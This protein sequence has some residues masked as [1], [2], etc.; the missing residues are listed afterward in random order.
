LHEFVERA[1]VAVL[2]DEVE[3]VGGFEHVDVFDDIGAGLQR[4]KDIDLVDSALL[5]FGNLLELLRL[6][7]L[8]RH[9]LLRHQVHRL[10]N[11]RVHSLPQLLL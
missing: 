4:R 1:A 6:H 8:Y 11:L 9:L 5:K 2:V 3:I 10:V 7:H